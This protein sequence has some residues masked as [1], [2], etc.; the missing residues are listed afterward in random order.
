MEL[1][2]MIKLKSNN[3]NFNKVNNFQFGNMNNSYNNQLDK[4]NIYSYSSNIYYYDNNQLNDYNN[5][6]NGM[7]NST[8]SFFAFA[9]IRATKSFSCSYFDNIHKE[10]NDDFLINNIYC[11]NTVNFPK[12]NINNNIKLSIKY[13]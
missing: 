7:N 6:Y 10:N 12:D 11:I 2:I 5:S 8:N 4:Y 1:F 13:N 3:N 9:K